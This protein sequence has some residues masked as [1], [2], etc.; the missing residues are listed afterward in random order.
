MTDPITNDDLINTL[1]LSLVYGVGPKTR[2][3]LLERFG[4]A[5][6]VLAAAMSDLREVN[7]VGA[8]LAHAI[9]EADQI[10]AEGEIALCRQ[11][12]IDILTE[13]DA[14]LSPPAPR[15]SR[16]AWRVVRSRPVEAERRS[17]H[18]HRRH[19]ARHAI[20]PAAGR[21]AGRRLG[22]GRIDDRQRAGPRNR[23]RR[24]SRRLAAGGRT[25]AV[26]ASGVMNIYPPEHDKLAE[27]VVAQRR[28]D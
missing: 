27:E 13:S 20:R 28:P 19:A 14:A 7:G 11:H 12:G 2:K 15:D 17:G 8:K 10:D 3:A 9:A 5:H 6:A 24:P 23:R 18:R 16:P 26:L 22:P 4:T 25:I 1:R 21:A